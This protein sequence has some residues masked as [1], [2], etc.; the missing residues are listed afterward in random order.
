MVITY[1]GAA[2]F[3]VQSGETVF[4]FN[5][6]SKNSEF[7]SPRFQANFVLIS[8]NHKD[9]NGAENI[10]SKEESKD[11]FVI[12]G[13]GEYEVGGV[14]IKGIFSSNYGN[15]IYTVS[16]ED[17]NLCHLGFIDYKDLTPEIKEE[18][19]ETDVLFFP[20]VEN[21]GDNAGKIIT[22]IGTRI[23]CP[24]Y[25]KESELKKSLKEFGE[26]SLEKMERLTIKKK[27]LGAEKT[28]IVVLTPAI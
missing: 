8:K 10:G 7:K 16:L 19:G 15:T 9:F 26:S 23:A 5:P 25:F 1:Y 21:N 11:V 24:F 6:P 20:L 2:C 18:I 28:K 17:I 13:P 12:N 27:D 22:Y 14:Y 4:V 3:K